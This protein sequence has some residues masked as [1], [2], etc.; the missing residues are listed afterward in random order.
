MRTTLVLH[1][2]AGS[3][4]LLSGYIA[5]YAAKGAALHRKSGMLFVYSM[6]AMTACG[7]VLAIGQKWWLVNIPAALL[8][9]YLVVTSLATVRPLT[10]GPRASRRLLLGGLFV[11]AGLGIA[12]LTLGVQTVAMG[13]NRFKIPAF[14]FF[15][16]GLVGILGSAGDFRI[17]RKGVR[18]SAPRL[19]RHLWRMTFALFIAAMSFFFGQAK[20]FPQPIRSSGL[21][22]L[23]ILAVL[24]TLLYWLWRV[25]FR[26]NLRG[27][28]TI[29]E[30]PE[31]YEIL[32]APPGGSPAGTGT[33]AGS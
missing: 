2:V 30:P 17:L 31:R 27:V 1:I 10:A 9:A 23:P 32:L 8:T 25:R 33:L 28:V 13:G 3:L 22:A 19:V 7:L 16:F 14:P 21:L 6:L 26:R 20:V 12:M 11:A 24:V 18:E 4:G 5:L 29:C 15:L